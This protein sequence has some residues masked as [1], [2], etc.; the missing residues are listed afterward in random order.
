M[1][2]LYKHF[3]LRAVYTL[4]FALSAVSITLSQEQDKTAAG[5]VNFIL[6]IGDGM[7]LEQARMAGDFANRPLVMTSL[8]VQGASKTASADNKI[9]DSA[10]A[11][12]ALACGKKVNN[13]VL[14]QLPDGTKLVS[15]ARKARDAGKRV[16]VISSVPVNHATPA[17]FYAN[18]TNR[19]LY[20][21][22]GLQAIASKFDVLGGSDLSDADGKN[23]KPE[24]K[25]SLW[26]LFKQGGYTI[27]RTP[28]A[29]KNCTPGSGRVAIIPEN[30]Y[31][32]A[33]TPFSRPFD[34]AKDITLAQMTAKSLEL[35]TCTNGF[36]LMVEGGAVDWSGHASDAIWNIA[37]VLAFDEAVAVAKAFAESHPNTLLVV[38]SDHE[39]GGLKMLDGYSPDKMRTVLS[40]QTRALSRLTDDLKKNVTAARKAGLT[41]ADWNAAK[42]ICTT[43]LGLKDSDLTVLEKD[44]KA[45]VSETDP[46]AEPKKLEKLIRE[47]RNLRDN[48]A[49]IEWTSKG[50]H[51]A[52]DVPVF[53]FGPDAK[54][55]EG[56][57]DNTQI[58]AHGI[59]FLLPK[60]P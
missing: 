42:K 14:G 32:E 1:K 49:G 35:L 53:A 45:A 55:F 33:A 39:T 40:R 51:S 21:D 27:A 28:E 19:N 2:N 8:P 13:R 30:I 22:I 47:A 56:T 16:G 5:P 9:T 36:F 3:F 54:R 18:A 57:Q 59:E 20:Y 4:T 29:L 58:Y 10:A 15:I 46:K 41:D 11:G 23:H 37:E 50:S 34:A 52:T 43:G 48:M 17:A 38:T 6:M 7:G 31:A 60:V 25:D 24:P 12:T 26:T 44:Y